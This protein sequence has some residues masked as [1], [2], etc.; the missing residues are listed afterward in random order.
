M[1]KLLLLTLGI[2][3]STQVS[4]AALTDQLTHY[5]NFNANSTDSVGSSNGTDV[6]SPTYATGKIGNGFFCASASSQY[7]DIPNNVFPWGTNT[8]TINFWMKETSATVGLDAFFMVA[9]TGQG[10]LL[11]NNVTNFDFAKPNVVSTNYLWTGIDTNWHMWTWVAD[12]A[13]MRYYLD[14][15]STPVAS[16]ANATNFTDPL[17]D[18][19]PLCAYRSGGTIQA[20]WYH[21]G[22][23]DEMGIWTR[24]LSTSEISQLYNSGAGLNPVAP[25]ASSPTSFG[26]FW[27]RKHY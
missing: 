22:A 5:Y 16:N 10:V 27:W 17:G 15:N 3:L 21:N 9:R 24:A 25:A 4:Y 20:G 18:N 8:V 12:G 14:G 23:F 7:T 13:G 6:N 19:I 1:K 11:Y 26:F 2:L